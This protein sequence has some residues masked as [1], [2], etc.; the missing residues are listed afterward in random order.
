MAKISGNMLRGHLEALVLATLER[1]EAHGFEI[2]Q[3]LNAAGHG[4]FHMKEGTLYPVLYRLENEGMLRARWE[5]ENT[6][7]KGPRKRLYHITSKGKKQLAERRDTWR[8][9]V[10]IVGGIVEA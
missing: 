4:A 5:R 1:G 8:E 10:G 9:F 7:K 6:P 3:R 2:M